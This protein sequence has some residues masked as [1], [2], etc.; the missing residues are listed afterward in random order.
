MTEPVEGR[1]SSS[2][3]PGTAEAIR[4]LIDD[5]AGPGYWDGFQRY[6]VEPDRHGKEWRFG[7]TLGFGGKLHFNAGRLY[8]SAYPEDIAR[9]PAIEGVVDEINMALW[10]LMHGA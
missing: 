9:F 3:G 8:V 6:M 1:G 5:L 7:G 2:V 10:G 4:A